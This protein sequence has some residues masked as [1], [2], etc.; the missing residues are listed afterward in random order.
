MQWEREG[1]GVGC[2]GRSL[3]SCFAC[4]MVVVSVGHL[5]GLSS[6]N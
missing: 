3:E 1:G 5:C 6:G 4:V 2:V